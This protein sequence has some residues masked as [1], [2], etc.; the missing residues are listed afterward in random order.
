LHGVDV[1]VVFADHEL[2]QGNL[3]CIDELGG[4]LKEELA[5]DRIVRGRPN[6]G[7]VARGTLHPNYPA[8]RFHAIYAEP[9]VSSH[10]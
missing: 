10:E 1:T 8:Q 2:G 4:G 6:Y 9:V 5:D 3:A 7:G